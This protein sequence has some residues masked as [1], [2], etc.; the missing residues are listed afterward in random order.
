V[1]SNGEHVAQMTAARLLD[2]DGRAEGL[3]DSFEQSAQVADSAVGH[4]PPPP[5]GDANVA[6]V[7]RIRGDVGSMAATAL[8]CR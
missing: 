1:R 5:A 6:S 2:Q 8:C 3:S 7:G 4:R